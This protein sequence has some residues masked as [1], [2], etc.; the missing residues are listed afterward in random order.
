MGKNMFFGVALLW[1]IPSMILSATAPAEA[2]TLKVSANSV[3]FKPGERVRIEIVVQGFTRVLVYCPD[4]G[5]FPASSEG[6]VAALVNGVAQWDIKSHGSEMTLPFTVALPRTPDKKIVLVVTGFSP[7]PGVKPISKTFE[8]YTQKKE[9]DALAS[10]VAAPLP[11]SQVPTLP[12]LAPALSLPQTSAANDGGPLGKLRT[13]ANATWLHEGSTYKD[14]DG[15]SLGHPRSF[16]NVEG[17]IATQL[18]DSPWDFGLAGGWYR[19]PSLISKN[20][21]LVGSFGRD[22]KRIGPVIRLRNN[23]AF[24][25]TA[26]GINSGDKVEGS[27]LFSLSAKYEQMIG[28]RFLGWLQGNATGSLLLPKSYALKNTLSGTLNGFLGSWS[29]QDQLDIPVPLPS[30]WNV[31]LLPAL[32]L[33]GV[34]N[35]IWDEEG[36]F[37]G[38]SQNSLDVYPYVGITCFFGPKNQNSIMVVGGAGGNNFKTENNNEGKTPRVGVFTNGTLV[39]EGGNRKIQGVD[40]STLE[41]Q[42]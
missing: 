6:T 10:A 35:A 32:S 36:N 22:V 24:L 14:S 19:S 29:V 18:A 26:V 15:R 42:Y 25:E 28:N 37:P 21:Q 33:G 16:T 41:D 20:P 8:L 39:L 2:V 12:H 40:E 23:E 5:L 4:L 1:A 7:V 17:S 13:Q 31:P 11:V 34:W 27:N 9:E 38:W 30:S 3:D